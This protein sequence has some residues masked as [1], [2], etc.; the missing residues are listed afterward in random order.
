M[1]MWLML[2]RLK[3]ETQ[4]STSPWTGLWVLSCIVCQ[5]SSKSLSSKTCLRKQGAPILQLSLFDR[6]SAAEKKKSPIPTSV[7][8]L[9]PQI[10]QVV[11]F[12]LAHKFPSG[13]VTSG[14]LIVKI[15]LSSWWNLIDVAFCPDKCS[16]NVVEFSRYSS[17]FDIHLLKV[18]LTIPVCFVLILLL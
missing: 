5:D 11:D 15:R 16:Y 2:R 6:L 7:L 9:K 12:L 3:A 14:T 10:I 13:S 1:L 8:Y 17:W 18:T 4:S